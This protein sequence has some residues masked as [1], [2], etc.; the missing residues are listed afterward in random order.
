[1]KFKNDAQRKAVFANMNQTKR[2]MSL[3]RNIS[4]KNTKPMTKKNVASW[5]CHP[6]RSD[7][8]GIDTKI[9]KNKVV[10]QKDYS[11]KELDLI[12]KDLDKPENYRIPPQHNRFTIREKKKGIYDVVDNRTGNTEWTTDDI[13]DAVFTM[14]KLNDENE[15]KRKTG[16]LKDENSIYTQKSSLDAKQMK[17]PKYSSV[18]WVKAPKGD[19]L[20]DEEHVIAKGTYNDVK[21]EPIYT[22][23]DKEDSV[24]INIESGKLDYTSKSPN[25]HLIKIGDST[26]SKENIYKVCEEIIGEKILKKSQPEVVKKMVGK[27]II[28][29]THQKKGND[30]YPVGI[31]GNNGI[32]FVAPCIE[33]Y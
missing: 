21:N 10:K 31:E 17:K 11:K 32:Y 27:N 9:T 1:M 33:D 26:F 14:D 23:F 4:A 15:Y 20:T 6:N 5:K 16:A 29:H 12:K 3:D 28:I 8:R 18:K 2:G 24:R 22:Q 7:I 25:A 13:G 30:L 19:M